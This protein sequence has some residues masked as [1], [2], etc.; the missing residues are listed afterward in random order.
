MNAGKCDDRHRFCPWVDKN[1]KELEHT[2]EDAEN[3]I[4]RSLQ[5]EIAS[6]FKLKSIEHS[7]IPNLV[8][9]AAE[10]LF[11]AE[12]LNAQGRIITVV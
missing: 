3:L 2:L 11:Q 6:E 7:R 12:T 8:E 10:Q 9:E 1:H 4:T 5:E